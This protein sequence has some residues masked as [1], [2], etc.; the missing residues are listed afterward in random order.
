M[1]HPFNS[2]TSRW[3]QSLSILNVESMHVGLYLDKVFVDPFGEGF[4]LHS[5]SLICKEGQVKRGSGRDNRRKEIKRDLILEQQE[6]CGV[7]IVVLY[8][9]KR[10]LPVLL[11]SDKVLK[12]YIDSCAYTADYT[13][14]HLYFILS[15]HRGTSS[16]SSV[17][18][19]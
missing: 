2:Q 15:F 3:C 11:F 18:H 1:F 4:L 7:I 19:I 9:L 8:F 17:S 6:N 10:N 16:L 13:T 12:I 14:I 5:V